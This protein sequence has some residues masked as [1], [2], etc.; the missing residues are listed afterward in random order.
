AL[1]YADW[2]RITAHNDN[3]WSGHLLP[4]KPEVSRS[5]ARWILPQWRTGLMR[6]IKA[7]GNFKGAALWQA[8]RREWEFH[9]LAN[10]CY[11]FLF[12]FNS[13]EMRSCLRPGRSL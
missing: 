7:Q 3:Q 11:Y 5:A 10:I 9:F 1:N 8:I 6:G 12:A 13:I 4:K 2:L